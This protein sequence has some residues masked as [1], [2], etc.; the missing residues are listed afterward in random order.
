MRGR[1]P[2][3]RKGGRPEP[4]SAGIIILSF[5]LCAGVTAAEYLR[6]AGA[7]DAAAREAAA[8]IMATGEFQQLSDPL[9][10]V[11]NDQIPLPEDWRVTP[12]LVDDEVVDQ[13]A[14]GDLVAMFQAAEREGVWF[15][16][17]SGYRSVADQ[18]IVLDRA[19]R[20]NRELGM[21]EE[22]ALE[23]ALRTIAQPGHSEHHTGLAVD[24]NDVS[25]DF[26]GTAA[27]RWLQAHGAE[28][29]F[30]QRYRPEKSAITG[31]EGESWHYR[32]VGKEHAQAMEKLGLCLEEY[33]ALLKK[34]GVR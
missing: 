30:I 28:Y 23:T 16:V 34:R 20:E 33:V 15:W 32:Y 31:I 14:A 4:L 8:G 25:G 13:R 7:A 2:A 17:A 12:R 1:G 27:Y 5:L 18:R 21:G 3:R 29:G 11:V 26:A 10:V 19:V 6:T 9:L 24:L 22:E